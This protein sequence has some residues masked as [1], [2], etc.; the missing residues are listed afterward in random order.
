MEELKYRVMV[1][2]DGDDYVYRGNLTWDAAWTVFQEIR[3][4]LAAR[5]YARIERE[6]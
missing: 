1:G 4:W 5:A 2:Q 6:E 3:L